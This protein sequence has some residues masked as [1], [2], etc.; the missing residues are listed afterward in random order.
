MDLTEIFIVKYVF[1][2]QG[3]VAY[4]E[5]C[6]LAKSEAWTQH[7]DD[8]GNVY[9]HNAENGHWVGYDTPQTVERKVKYIYQIP[10][11]IF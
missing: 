10:F 3:Y 6:N 11:K 7:T 4:F 9:M 8:T 5:I 1:F 2:F